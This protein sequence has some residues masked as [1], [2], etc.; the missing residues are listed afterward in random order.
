[1]GME[2]INPKSNRKA[3]VTI[4]KGQYQVYE[5]KA[6]AIPTAITPDERLVVT[7]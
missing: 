3:R 1:M 7:F 6:D 2:A 4:D 5:Y